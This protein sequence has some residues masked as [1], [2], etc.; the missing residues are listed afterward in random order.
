[1]ARLLG[2]VPWVVGQD[3]AHLDEI[4]ERFDYPR[5]QLM[6]DLEGRLFFVGVHPFTPDTLIDVQIT[7]GI[8]D[9]QYADWF[10]Q[11]MRLNSEEATRLLA[12]GRTV[13]DMAAGSGRDTS[14]DEDEAAPL[15]RALAKLRLSLGSEGAE[16]ADH[17]DVCLGHAPADTL[18][19][20]RLAI[21]ERRQIE[22]EYYSLGRDAMTTRTVDP[23][24]LFSHDGGWYLSGWCHRAGGERVFGVDRIRTLTVLDSAV[25][26]DLPAGPP[27]LKVDTVDRTVTLRLAPEAAWAADYYRARQRTERPDGSVEAVFAVASESWLARLLVQLGPQVQVAAADEAGD[28]GLQASTAARMLERYRQ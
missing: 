1:M 5:E 19:D 16:S 9:I 7:D 26:V 15:L 2:V 28:A 11:P 20:L 4:A 14:G 23:A 24:R 8:V 27:A 12:A 10:S 13:L 3:G 6:E 21:S 25:E 17:V 22:I 18:A